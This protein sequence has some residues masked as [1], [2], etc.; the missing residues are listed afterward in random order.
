M[1]HKNLFIIT[2]NYN[3]KI[4]HYNK[5]GLFTVSSMFYNIFFDKYTLKEEKKDKFDI[6]DINTSLIIQNQKY[7]KKLKD[8]PE[9]SKHYDKVI[10]IYNK[11]TSPENDL[12]FIKIAKNGLIFLFTLGTPI[13]NSCF[14]ETLGVKNNANSKEIRS[15]FIKIAINFHPDKNEKSLVN[16]L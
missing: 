14:Y 13:I 7:L 1:K 9:L 15:N 8:N 16:F 12:F 11:E 2:R 5:A 6:L 4:Y 10:H 3:L